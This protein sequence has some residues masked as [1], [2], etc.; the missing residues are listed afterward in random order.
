MLETNCM[1][2]QGWLASSNVLHQEGWLEAPSLSRGAPASNETGRTPY[3]FRPQPRRAKTGSNAY[4]L[5]IAVGQRLWMYSRSAE[6][7]K[8]VPASPVTV[9]RHRMTT[10]QARKPAGPKPRCYVGTW[11]WEHPVALPSHKEKCVIIQSSWN[12]GVQ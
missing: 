2:P 5:L 10:K 12:L 7:Q 8:S 6:R 9:G 3:S 11:A 1:E 4:Q